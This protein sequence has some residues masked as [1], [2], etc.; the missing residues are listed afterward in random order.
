[1]VLTLQREGAER[2]PAA[3]D[4]QQ[5]SWSALT[6]LD[7][8]FTSV[9]QRVALTDYHQAPLPLGAVPIDDECLFFDLTLHHLTCYHT[10]DLKEDDED[11][12]QRARAFAYKFSFKL[13]HSNCSSCL[14]IL[15]FT[16]IIG[17]TCLQHHRTD[18]HTQENRQKHF[19]TAT[20]A[21]VRRLT[22]SNLG[23]SAVDAS[24]RVLFHVGWK[25]FSGFGGLF[26]RLF[27]WSVGWG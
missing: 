27:S 21:L 18:R 4:A 6:F 22:H 8:H 2:F 19:N 25:G 11:V 3:R 24:C 16:L 10:T 9:L 17:S 26:Y 23:Q 1:M 5:L 12:Q 15:H 7:H 14:D 20:L 13:L